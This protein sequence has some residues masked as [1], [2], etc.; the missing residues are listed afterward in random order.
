[1]F[2]KNKLTVRHLG[3]KV[4]TFADC[5]GIDFEMEVVDIGRCYAVH[6]LA[7]LE[8]RMGVLFDIDL[9][10]DLKKINEIKCYSFLRTFK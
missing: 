4:D 9:G 3:H 6:M 7:A 8:L 10:K 2:Q 1:M 5:L